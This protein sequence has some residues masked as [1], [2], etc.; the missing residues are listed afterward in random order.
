MY[1]KSWTGLA[2][3][4]LV[5]ACASASSEKVRAKRFIL[6][7]ALLAKKAIL[8]KKA[9]LLGGAVGVAGL[10]HHKQ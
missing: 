10:I 2:V 7:K 8:A 3:L 4:L 1:L 5:V 6:A 9:L